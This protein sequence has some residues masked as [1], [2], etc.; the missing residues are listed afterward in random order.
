MKNQ[1]SRSGFGSY[2]LVCVPFP[3]KITLNRTFHLSD[4]RGEK[5]KNPN[6]KGGFPAG[7][8]S[9]THSEVAAKYRSNELNELQVL[10]NSSS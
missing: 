10:V 7:P 2:L 1:K 5:E 8:R 3:W 6:N 9:F 4:L